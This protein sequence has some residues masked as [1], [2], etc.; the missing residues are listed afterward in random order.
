MPTLGEDAIVKAVKF[1]IF[2]FLLV[3]SHSLWA[4]EPVYGTSKESKYAREFSPRKG[5]ASVY[6]LQ[7]HESSGTTSP[8][9][10]LNNY[11]VG[12]TVPGTFAVWQMPAGR[13]NIRVDGVNPAQLSLVLG[14]GKAYLIRLSVRQTGAGLVPQLV[15][16]PESYRTDLARF[17][18]LK[19][20]R[21]VSFA[22]EQQAVP[23]APKVNA[24]S[25]PARPATEAVKQER[26]VQVEES[27]ASAQ[28]GRPI[29]PG[30]V[31]VIVKAGALTLSEESQNITVGVTNYDL[32]FDDS[33]SGPFAVEAYYQY[34]SGFTIGGEILSY[35][36]QF[37]TSSNLHDMDVLVFSANAKKYFRDRSSFQPFIGAGIGYALTDISGPILTGNTSGISYQLMVG[38]EYRTESIGLIAEYKIIGADTEDDSGQSIDVSGSGIFAGVAFHF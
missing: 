16:L 36:A 26:T 10:W 32:A 20:P 8:K 17:R 6:I 24:S 12:R 22:A 5:K 29:K 11:E 33:A 9:I 2:I 23:I 37:T 7:T 21:D 28:P 3:S 34:P 38:A 1:L 19:N 27:D 25:E 14:A 30:G 35:T 4:A 15:A 13:L 18:W 31:A